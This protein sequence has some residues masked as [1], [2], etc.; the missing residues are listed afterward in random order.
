MLVESKDEASV[1]CEDAVDWLNY[2]IRGGHWAS[3]NIVNSP[4]TSCGRS[5]PSSNS[6][7]LGSIATV[8]TDLSSVSLESIYMEELFNPSVSDQ[9]SSTVD[10]DDDVCME[11]IERKTSSTVSAN[12]NVLLYV[13]FANGLFSTTA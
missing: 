2:L 1:V 6:D 8:D 3:A 12:G 11:H 9:Q 10:V 5:S 7:H 13:M 4:E